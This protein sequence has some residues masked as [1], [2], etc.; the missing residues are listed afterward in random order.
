MPALPPAGPP[1]ELLNTPGLPVH[2]VLHKPTAPHSLLTTNQMPSKPSTSFFPPIHPFEIRY[3]LLHRYTP[4]GSDLDSLNKNR[5][6]AIGL[7]G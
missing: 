3:T 1:S 7:G 5:Q 6:D 2:L 4:T